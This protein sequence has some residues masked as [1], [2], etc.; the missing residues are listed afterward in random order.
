MS[1]H[2]R[3]DRQLFSSVK[4]RILNFSTKLHPTA[5]QQM[6]RHTHT[7]TH[8]HVYHMSLNFEQDKKQ[9]K[10]FDIKTIDKC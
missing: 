2:C 4:V 5:A 10:I 6:H 1:K 7:H 9:L 3:V 8:T